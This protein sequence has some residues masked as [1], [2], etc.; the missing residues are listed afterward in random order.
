[1]RAWVLGEG[2]EVGRW[3]EGRPLAGACVG[4][5]IH[6]SLYFEGI[7]QPKRVLKREVICFVFYSED[8]L[9]TWNNFRLTED[10]LEFLYTVYPDSPIILPH[11]L[12][13]L[14]S[15]LLSLSIYMSVYT[16]VYAYFFNQWQAEDVLPLFNA[17][18]HFLM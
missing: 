12:Y 2:Q 5:P 6:F 16:Y 3:V 9:K 1:M 18:I 15:F 8:F 4:A 7:K 14:Y 13:H 17:S 10:F 11:L